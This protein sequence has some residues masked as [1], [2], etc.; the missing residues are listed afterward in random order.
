MPNG[1]GIGVGADTKEFAAAIKSG[2]IDPAEQAQKALEQIGDAANAGADDSQVAFREQQR[3]T[4]QLRTDITQ[5]NTQIKEQARSSWKSSSDSAQRAVHETTEGLDE[6]KDSARQN[7]IETAASFDGSFDS[8]AGGAQGLL[9]EMTAGFGPAG[10]LAGVVAAGA[11]GLITSQVDGL[12]QAT[13]AE[14]QQVANLEGQLIAAGDHGKRSIDDIHQA[15]SDMATDTDG[16]QAVISLQKAW[17]AAHTAGADYESIVQSIASADPASIDKA[18]R[19]VSALGDQYQ[20]AAKHAS[21]TGSAG[22][23]AAYQQADAAGTLVDALQKAKG[24][25]QQAE[26][27]QELAAK[28]GISNWQRKADLIS[29]L[30]GSY[31]D[32]AGSIDDYLDKESGMLDVQKYINAMDKRAEALA[33]YKDDLL[34]ADL[35]PEAKSFLE[36]QGADSASAMVAGYK[37]ASPGQREALDRIWTAAGRKNV[38][39]YAQAVGSDL[40]DMQLQGPRIELPP[41]SISALDREHQRAQEWLRQHPVSVGMQ[42]VTVAHG[43]PIFQ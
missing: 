40:E 18:L 41:I 10:V 16:S 36:S 38:Q 5:L 27:A 14:R 9:S 20:E 2:M 29:Q 34:K 1:I 37:K 26:R 6:V 32:A 42:I 8:I 28:A 30:S 7:A 23:K 4:E 17:Q 22:T 31:D 39:S 25:A 19:A 15:I 21:A 11:I 33:S 3:S 24:Q 43:K 13:E 12:Q 35:T